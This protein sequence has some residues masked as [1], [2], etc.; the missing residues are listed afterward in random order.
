MVKT[1]LENDKCPNACDGAVDEF[2]V[3]DIEIQIKSIISGKCYV[4]ND[5]IYYI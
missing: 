5:A 2:M 4:N 1:D 3:Y